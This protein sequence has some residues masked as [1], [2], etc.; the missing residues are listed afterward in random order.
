MPLR[1]AWLSSRVLGSDLCSTTQIQLA[2]GL[3][4]RGHKVEFYSPG[5]S[6]GNSFTHY[7]IKRSNLRGLQSKSVTKR[8]SEHLN[9]IN[10]C[11]IIMID[12]SIFGIVDKINKP[13]ILMD[14][15][16]PAD[17][18]FLA[19][20]QWIPWRRA[21]SKSIRGT[22]VSEAHRQFVLKHSK[23]LKESIHVIH[24]GADLQLF[25]PRKKSG[26]LKLAYHGR[27]D[28][29]RG[30]M[31]LPMILAGLQ[32]NGVDASLHI[33]GKG[34]AIK[35]LKNITLDGLEVSESVSQQEIASLLSGYDVGFL[36][37][38]E[39]DVWSLA[40]PLKR[41]E[42]LASG[43]VICGIYHGGHHIE[44]SGEWLQLFNQD[45]FIKDSVKWITSL[46]RSRLTSLQQQSREYAEK[47]LC[48]SH[49]V[50]I[51]ESMILS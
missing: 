17:S 13:V 22:T 14:R 15:G 29:N 5:I 24:A 41:S 33:H 30:V 9:K 1:I 37:M 12:W 4:A 3:V 6:V 20:L 45:S 31:A 23:A 51:L 10:E 32:S 38:P 16:P 28:V 34:D 8:M 27:V 11:A 43:M 46:D 50:D 42:Y 2:N 44:E 36:P 47:N 48:W 19:K 35:R 18:G 49:S 25:K 7:S 26:P 40:S 21:W 39:N